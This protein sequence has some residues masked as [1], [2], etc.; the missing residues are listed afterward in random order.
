MNIV[1]LQILF[2]Q[3]IQDINPIFEVEQRP[4]SFTF[5]NYINKAIDNYLA[6]KY[7]NLPTFQQRLIAIDLN[8]DE[9]K[10][11]I[12]VDGVLSAQK[13]LTQYNWSTR[14]H[15]YRTPDDILIPISISCSV[16][17]TEVYSM[18]NQTLFADWVSRLQAQ[19]LVSHSG[20]KVMYPRP[21]A[22]W[23][24]PYYIMLIG[25]AYTTT[26]IPGN[27]V[28]L[29]KPYKLSFEYSE[30]DGVGTGNLDIFAISNGSYFLAKSNILYV[31]STGV[32]TTFRTGSKVQKIAGYNT[33]TYIDE[34]LKIGTPWGYTDVPDLP[35][36]LHDELVEKAVSL[37]VDEAKFKLIKK[38]AS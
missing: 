35:D 32:P 8:G 9:L 25:D 26:I 13:D 12:S 36:Y 10:D 18:T 28:Y 1:E 37:F 5:C 29:R 2:Q 31:N 27:L 24:D 23:E 16:S 20:D 7:I 17:R 4:D 38:S 33:I 15:R 3:K 11:L 6:N 14:G 34:Q 21:V 30:L 19:R 22:V